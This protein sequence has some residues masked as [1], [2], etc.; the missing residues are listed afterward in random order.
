MTSCCH[1]W[2]ALG[3][4]NQSAFRTLRVISIERGVV[5]FL[6][7]VILTKGRRIFV[8]KKVNVDFVHF[9]TLAAV[10]I[11]LSAP[12]RKVRLFMLR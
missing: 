1:V 5:A 9:Y 2:R 3:E 7:C 8:A 10:N 12:Y 4:S 11:K 6:R